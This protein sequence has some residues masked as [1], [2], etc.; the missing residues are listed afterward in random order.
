M[1]LTLIA[2]IVTI[3]W[4]ASLGFYIYSSRRQRSLQ[5]EIEALRQKL[6][7]SGLDEDG[8]E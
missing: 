2:A 4:L 5:E 8:A 6:D 7:E 1:N 3:L